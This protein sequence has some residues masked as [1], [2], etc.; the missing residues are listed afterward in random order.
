M[1]TND[2][3]VR[4]I[5]SE[6]RKIT[7]ET[8]EDLML[9]EQIMN[10]VLAALAHSDMSKPPPYFGQKVHRAIREISGNPD[11][12]K[13]YKM[14]FNK[15][16]LELYPTLRQMVNESPNPFRTAALLAL[17]G[18]VI[19]L[20]A[21]NNIRLLQTID[22]TLRNPPTI[23]YITDLE[24]AL[25]SAERILYI[26]DNAGEIVLDRIFIEQFPRNKKTIYA[27]RGGPVIND[28]TVEDAAATDMEKAAEVISNGSDAPGI[29]LDDCSDEF[30]MVFNN[31]DC[32]IAKGM[33]NFESLSSFKGKEIFFIFL[34][35]CN[36]VAEH[37]GC[38]K[39]SAIVLKKN[40][41]EVL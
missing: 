41:E 15:L 4:C 21:N 19:D 26:G 5:T 25:E 33:G 23:D 7:S 29:I 40:K 35:K 1:H 9:K 28:A 12:Y 6:V 11:P 36:L 3:C 13:Q 34:V 39:G 2:D 27:V 17:A 30:R 37:I 38:P 14:H 20:A 24:K 16:A 32:I 10:G 31:A 22:N 8:V 18:N